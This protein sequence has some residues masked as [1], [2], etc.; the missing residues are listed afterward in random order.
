MLWCR[1]LFTRTNI[2][3][4]NEDCDIA[5]NKATYDAKKYREKRVYIKGL[6]KLVDE[7]PVLYARS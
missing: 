5:K 6:V 7:A 2:V 4:V 1:M 3:N